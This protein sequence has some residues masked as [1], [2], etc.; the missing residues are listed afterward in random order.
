MNSSPA[1]SIIILAVVIGFVFF[2]S[3]E[4]F[5]KGTDSETDSLKTEEQTM[6][7][8]SVVLPI[9]LVCSGGDELKLWYTEISNSPGPGA[10]AIPETHTMVEIVLPNEE[11][12]TFSRLYGVDSTDQY[13]VDPDENYSFVLEDSGASARLEELGKVLYKGCVLK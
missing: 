6:V 10:I 2:I 4:L 12:L 9:T 13:Y 3:N 8:T 11:V 5:R 7:D 1:R